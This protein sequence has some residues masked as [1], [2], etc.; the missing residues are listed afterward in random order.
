MEFIEYISDDIKLNWCVKNVDG[1]EMNVYFLLFI[2][3]DL[4]CFS[5]G[6]RRLH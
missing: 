5:N 6:R 1:E 2:W 4:D 3:L